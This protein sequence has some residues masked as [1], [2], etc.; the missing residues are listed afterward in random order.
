MSS[1]DNLK[2]NNDKVSKQQQQSSELLTRRH[3]HN[4]TNRRD[5]RLDSSVLRVVMLLNIS[6]GNPRSTLYIHVKY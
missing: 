2:V 5:V 6:Q 1:K 4:K 3:N